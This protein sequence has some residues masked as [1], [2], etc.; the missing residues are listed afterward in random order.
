MT[1][2][3]NPDALTDDPAPVSLPETEPP[4]RGDDPLTD[5]TVYL[6][7]GPVAIQQRWLARLEAGDPYAIAIHEACRKIE[8]SHR[9]RS[10]L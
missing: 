5:Q 10:I 8:E 3:V 9:E 1:Q 2:F 4:D 7:L 6:T